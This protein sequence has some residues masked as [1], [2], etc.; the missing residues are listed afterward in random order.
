M[1]TLMQRREFARTLLIGTGAACSLALPAAHAALNA[2]GKRSRLHAVL[3]RAEGVDGGLRWRPIEQCTS[4]ACAASQRVRVVIDSLAFPLTF[5]PLVIDAMLATR[6]GLKPFR[7]ATY[8]PGAVSPVSKP[9]AFEV[10]TS[11]LAGFRV[12]H[13]NAMRG[14]VSV[15]GSALLGTKRPVLAAGR[16]LMLMGDTEHAPDVD[17]LPVPAEAARPVADAPADALAFAW[18]AFSVMPASA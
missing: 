3:A 10:D 2:A 13:A 8:Q 9:F 11:G 18:L 1:V 6:D 16:Y 14:D 15:A 17:I 5:R 4:V 7:V 12:E